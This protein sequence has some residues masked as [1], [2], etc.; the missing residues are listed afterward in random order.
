MT[1]EVRS[2]SSVLSP[3]MD[4]PYSSQ[5]V[6]WHFPPNGWIKC[7]VDGSHLSNDLKAACGG[8]FRDAT[9]AWLGGFSNKLGYCSFVMAEL[10]GVLTA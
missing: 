1:A 3:H 5:L 2:C 7:N 9:G 8:V 6:G 4:R 10:R